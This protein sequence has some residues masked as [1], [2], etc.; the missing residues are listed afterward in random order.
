MEV[1]RFDKKKDSF[2]TL[3]ELFKTGLGETNR[4]FWEWKYLYDSG[5]DKQV[6]YVIEDNSEIVAMMGFVP[7]DYVDKNGKIHKFVQTCDLVVRPDYRGRG[8][9]YKICNYAHEDLNNCGY[10]AFIGFPNY[11]SLHGFGKMGYKQI[12][13]MGYTVPMN[14][15]RLILH[16]TGIESKYVNKSNY[17]VSILSSDFGDVICELKDGR[18][19]INDGCI[20]LDIN[21]QYIKWRCDEYEGGDYKAITVRENGKLIAYFIILV[22][23]GRIFTAGKIVNF[24]IDKDYL[25]KIKCI[26]KEVKRATHSF[27][28]IIDFYAVWSDDIQKFIV[29]AFEIKKNNIKKAGIFVMKILG[30]RDM[31]TDKL[32]INHLDTDL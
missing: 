16:K 4:H 21:P 23:K 5:F 9:F 8:L 32:F 1:R 22:T 27:A 17:D 3:I 15:T 6:M 14:Y 20:R 2:L 25:G 13:I 31:I 28:D 29:E 26:A 7:Q 24:D 10:E 19:T 30:D 11:N 12:D 18:N